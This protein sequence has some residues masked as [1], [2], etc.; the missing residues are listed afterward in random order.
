MYQKIILASGSPRRRELFTK[1]GIDFQYSTS[2]VKELLTDSLPPEELVIKIAAMKA[3]NVSNIYS[4]AFIVG[5]D[6]VIYFEGNV[7]G[8]PR[9]AAD[10][11]KTLK[12][13]SGK[14]HDV[15]TGVAIVHKES[16][17]CERFYQKT[18]VFFRKLS[19]SLIKWY[20][21]TEE[22][23]DKAGSYG[24]QGKGSLLVEKII[25]DYD[26]VVGMPMGMLMDAFIKL[27]IAPFGGFSYDVQ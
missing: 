8:K 10:A 20:V 22:P 5:A 18:E 23:L 13:L 26:N 2:T 16:K 14:K 27:N 1:L 6:T 4:E 19:D 17:I 9:D 11:I 24:I 3:Y 12:M 21:D 25:G 7:I 15:Y